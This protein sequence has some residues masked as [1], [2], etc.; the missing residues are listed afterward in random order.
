MRKTV[1]TGLAIILTAGMLGCGNKAEN[2][3]VLERRESQGDSVEG[4]SFSLVKKREYPMEFSDL[5][6]EDVILIED[7][8]KSG[9]GNFKYG[10]S[11]IARGSYTHEKGAKI[12][13]PV[14]VLKTGMRVHESEREKIVRRLGSEMREYLGREF[15]RD[16]MELQE[17]IISGKQYSVPLRT[18]I[19]SE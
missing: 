12:V 17:K 15:N 4:D 1:N 11:M 3:A 8:F 14:F 19:L 5:K 18:S 6:G 16:Y 7:I 2:T 13:V 10:L 9:E